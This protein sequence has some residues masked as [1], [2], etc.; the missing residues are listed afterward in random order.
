MA[1][2]V[3]V[4]ESTPFCASPVISGV[5][6]DVLVWADW[7]RQSTSDALRVLGGGGEAGVVV[8]G[9]VIGVVT[10]FCYLGDVLDSEGGA[11]RAVRARVASAWG[12]W[13][14]ILGQLL[15]KFIPLARRGMVF[16]ACIGSVM[17]GGE[18]LSLTKRLESVNI[19]VSDTKL[20]LGFKVCFIS[21]DLTANKLF[22]IDP[23]AITGPLKM[24]LLLEV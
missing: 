23:R 19:D 13:R 15:N 4:L 2:A 11:E 12:K 21:S 5:I 10:Q 8:E 9:G 6:G 7:V 17:Y 1:C 14:E 22:P 16:D 20:M 24:S 18:T 3:E